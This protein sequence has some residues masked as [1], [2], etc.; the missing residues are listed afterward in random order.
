MLQRIVWLGIVGGVLLSCRT[1]PAY[2][3]LYRSIIEVSPDSFEWHLAIYMDVRACL[4]CC[5][6]MEAWQELEK[7]LPE[8]GCSLTLWCPQK[9]SVDVAVAMELEGM[10][11]QVHILSDEVIHALKWD[12]SAT[13]IKVLY[14]EQGTPVKVLGP[15]SGQLGSRKEIEQLLYEVCSKK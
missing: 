12:K 6:N 2:D 5:E 1:N 11:T 10:K 9:D 13:P 14:D 4:S 7:R 8:C 3:E 15:S